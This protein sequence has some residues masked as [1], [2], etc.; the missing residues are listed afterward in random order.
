MD[1]IFLNVVKD[2]NS[3][4]E[5]LRNFLSYELFLTEFLRLILPTEIASK[6]NNE[7]IETQKRIEGNG[8]PDLLI[9]NENC[10][11]LFEIKIQDTLLTSNQ[12]TNYLNYLQ[13][14]TNK[15]KLLILIIP[16]SYTHINEWEERVKT[17]TSNIPTKTIYWENILYILQNHA[18]L[19]FNQCFVEFSHLLSS[20]F[21]NE[22]INFNNAQV[23]IM[24]QKSTPEIIEKLFT[25][26]DGVRNSCSKQVSSRY[27]RD[28]GEFCIY[29]RDKKNIEFLYFGVW[30][31]FWKN[32]K[33]PLCF[34]VG[35]DFDKEVIDHFKK[36]H[37]DAITHDGWIMSW[38]DE[39][40]F[41]DEN[42][43]EKINQIIDREIKELMSKFNGHKALT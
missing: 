1:S 28:K 12:P 10:E 22:K 43:N 39:D 23:T 38:I 7:D 40:I 41:V 3:M 35:E 4:T 13:K 6:I 36:T 25:I 5:L 9:Q 32:Y 11:I 20:W 30:F 31:D 42:C 21:E 33:K 17:S 8:Q 34:G 27:T 19:K 29:F 37:P 15:Y 26:V 18:F 24:N 2:E 14:D 16:K